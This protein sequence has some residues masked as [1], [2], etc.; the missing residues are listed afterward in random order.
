MLMRT[1][2]DRI[3]E[4]ERVL[5]RSLINN[6][7]DLIWLK[8]PQGIYLACNHEFEK[9]FGHSEVEITGKTDFDFV[10]KELAEA[11]RLNDQLA[12]AAGKPTSNE[13]WITYASNGHRALLVTTKT[14]IYDANG[15]LIG[16]LGVGHEVTEIHR[17][18]EELEQH[19]NNLQL[20]VDERTAELNGAHQKLLD[21]EFAMEKVGIGITWADTE[22]GQ[23]LYVNEYHANVLGYT[24]EELLALRVSDIDPNFPQELYRQTIEKIREQG[25]VQFETTQLKKTGETIP[26]EMTVYYHAGED[27]EGSRLMGV[28]GILCKR[29]LN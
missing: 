19:R 4:E 27:G 29:G 13:E 7:P 2:K 18:H 3:K 25:F 17:I 1:Q 15:R 24:R 11:F 22:T 26:A 8:D 9:F 10:P 14:P 12:V 5:L 21:T 16:V 20:L 23:F 6:I 28:S